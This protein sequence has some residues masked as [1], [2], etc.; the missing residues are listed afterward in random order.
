MERLLGAH[1]LWMSLPTVSS[2][3]L[4]ASSATAWSPGA[5]GFEAVA[6]GLDARICFLIWAVFF[7]LCQELPSSGRPAA[8]SCLLSRRAAFRT[9]PLPSPSVP[10]SILSISH[11]FSW[12][13]SSPQWAGLL[14]CRLLRAMV[15]SCPSRVSHL[16]GHPVPDPPSSSC[17]PHVTRRLPPPPPFPPLPGW[18]PVSPGQG[19]ERAGLLPTG[20]PHLSPPSSHRCRPA[21][22]PSWR[23]PCWWWRCSAGG[24][25]PT[26]RT[27]GQCGGGAGPSLSTTTLAVALFW[28][29]CLLTVF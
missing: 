7:P 24:A 26:D 15:L 25:A 20:G 2:G 4:P 21:C 1:P 10:Q 3:L 19:V 11:G 14:S 8:H 16:S 28:W 27:A 13:T 29:C 22:G 9:P 12:Q 18:L 6:H 5:S 23:C 17:S